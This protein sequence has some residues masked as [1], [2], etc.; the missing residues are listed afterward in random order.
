MARRLFDHQELRFPLL[1]AEVEA[2]LPP[3][4][5]PMRGFSPAA[6]RV[7]EQAVSE[8]TAMGAFK[9]GTEHVLL[10]LLHPPQSLP[11]RLMQR[12]GITRELVL[13]W[14]GQ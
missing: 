13:E 12:Y 14:A 8:A 9:A 2:A 5:G 1:R 11:A 4:G 10:A 3:G 7:M 6:M